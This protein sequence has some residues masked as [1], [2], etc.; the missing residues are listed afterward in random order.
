MSTRLLQIRNTVIKCPSTYVGTESTVVDSGRNLQGV[1]IGAVIRES[2]ASVDV[3]WSY[4][5]VE[6]WSNILKLFNSKYGGSFYNKVTFFNQVSGQLETRTMYVSDRTSSGMI[7]FDRNGNPRG[8]QDAKL[9]LVE[10]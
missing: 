1:A 6:S 4:I 3:S 8:Y 2:L 9:S 5:S 7:V 10:V